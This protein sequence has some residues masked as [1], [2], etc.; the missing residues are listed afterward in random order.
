MC[1]IYRGRGDKAMKK[2]LLLLFLTTVLCIV[3]SIPVFADDAL[4]NI[5]IRTISEQTESP[6]SIP[7]QRLL[8]RLIDQ[9]DLLTDSE[10]DALLTQLNEISERQQCDVAVV[11]VLSLEGKTSSAYADDFYDYNGYGM[12]NNDDGI[13]LLI[14]MQDRDWAITTH[15]FAI[16]AFTDQGQKYMVDRFK[17]DLS[18]G[19]YSDAFE[20]FATLCDQFITQAKTGE[21]YDSGNLPDKFLN[22]IVVVIV[23]LIGFASSSLIMLPMKKKLKNVH[24]Q[25][26]ATDYIKA[27][28]VNITQASEHFLYHTI[29]KTRRNNNSGSGSSGSS[30]HVSSSGRSHG[31]SSGKF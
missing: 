6:S 1:F 7:Q 11:T 28:S 13:L 15:G 5:P 30:I 25:E 21:P 29:S 16:T 2:R 10:E 31:G 8:P 26:S 22:I 27:G 24:R 3:C 23:L 17:N 9:A 12:G 4:E 20:E 18:K 14:S 19:N